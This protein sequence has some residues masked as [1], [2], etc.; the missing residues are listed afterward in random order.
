MVCFAVMSPVVS[1]ALSPPLHD[2]L[3]ENVT[4]HVGE[5]PDSVGAKAVIVK[6]AAIGVTVTEALA[7]ETLGANAESENVPVFGVDTMFADVVTVGANVVSARVAVCGVIVFAFD[8]VTL[9]AEVLRLS[10][11]VVGV[12]V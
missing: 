9:G 12:A 6:F 8:T 3:P 4:V 10:G 5:E 2:S 7:T 11:A 1:L